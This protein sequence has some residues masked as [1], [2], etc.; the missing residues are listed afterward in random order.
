MSVKVVDICQ[1]CDETVLRNYFFTML[2]NLDNT[3]ANAN[4]KTHTILSNMKY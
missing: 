2:E 3:V 4:T 1:V